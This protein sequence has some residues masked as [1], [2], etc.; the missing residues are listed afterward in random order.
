MRQALREVHGF[1][2]AAGLFA[3]ATVGAF[4]RRGA[5]PF[6]PRLLHTGRQLKRAP[7]IEL[8]APAPG[9]AAWLR[10]QATAAPRNNRNIKVAFLKRELHLKRCTTSTPGL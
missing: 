2:Y 9:R 5:R 1:A 6:A 8:C 4:G 3:C 7:R 10:A